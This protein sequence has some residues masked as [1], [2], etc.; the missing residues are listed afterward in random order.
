MRILILTSLYPNPW[1][2]HRAQF[3]RQQFAALAAKHEVRLI[4]P[5]A[6][7]EQLRRSPSA[8]PQQCVLRDGMV[9][10]HP[11]YV[12]PPKMLRSWHGAC[13]LRSVRPAFD[14]AIKALRPQVV[15]GSW[16]YPD[17]WAAMNLARSANLSI[18]A[19]V[20]GSDVL[21][22]ASQG[23]RRQQTIDALTGSDAVIAVSQQLAERTAALGVDSAKLFVNY[24]GVDTGLFSPDSPDA[25]RAKLNLRPD[26][27]VLFVGNLVPVKGLKILIDACALLRDRSVKFQCRLIGQGP[28]RGMLSRRIRKAALTEHIHLHGPCPLEQLPDWYRA[29]NLLVLPSFSEGI[30]NVILEAQA[31]GTPIVASRVGGIPEILDDDSLVPPNNPKLLADAIERTLA[32]PNVTSRPMANWAD[33]A[34]QLA[35]ILSEVAE[36]K[37]KAA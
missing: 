20:H 3:N 17:A 13:Y 29:A 22:L 14:R 10:E 30:P 28:L 11:R 32:Q 7:P 15:L 12:Y 5:V 27:L 24:N 18:V 36:R 31:C 4:A 1:E 34:A 35:D 26:P 25:A 21:L 37:K 19:K 8:P 16:A 6:W 9:I 23:G 33:S 2:P